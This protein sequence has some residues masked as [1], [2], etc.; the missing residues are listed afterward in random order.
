MEIGGT[1]QQRISSCLEEMDA[2]IFAECPL[3]S[4]MVVAEKRYNSGGKGNIIETIM[5]IMSIRDAKSLSMEMTLAELGMDSLMT[6]EI[7]QT[8]ERDYDLVIPAQELRSMTIA[9]LVKAAKKQEFGDEGGAGKSNTPTG[10]GMLI[11]N[12][13]DEKN[14]EQ[15]CLRLQSRAFEHGFRTLIIPGIEGMGG[16]TWYNLAEHLNSNVFILQLKKTSYAT[17][18]DEVFNIIQQDVTDLFGNEKKFVIVGYSFGALLALKCAEHLEAQGKKGKVVFI[19]GSPKFLK[20]LASEQVGEL[21]EQTIQN[22]VLMNV[23][24]MIFPDDN[25]DKMKMIMS[26]KLWLERLR[27]LLDVVQ[28]KIVY[29]DEYGFSMMNA[30]V[31]RIKMVLAMNPDQFKKISSPITLIRPTD[32]S[33]MSIEEDYGLNKYSPKEVNVQYLEGNHTTILDN[34]KLVTLLNENYD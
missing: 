1:L 27:K 7:Q 4:S 3:V 28:E 9:Q 8:L 23:I 14:S 13:G 20:T 31:N 19:D 11:R 18:V 12:L 16:K 15:T 6:V 10:I 30:L 21:N 33:I 24:A 29:S 2:L 26:F 22:L 17:T 25:G 5:N 34:P 32:Q